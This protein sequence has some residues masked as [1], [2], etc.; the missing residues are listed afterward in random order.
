MQHLT[1]TGLQWGDEGKGKIVDVLADHYDVI[2]RFQGGHNAGHTLMIDGKTYKLSLL[3]SGIV[4]QDK[5]CVI[6]NGVVLD[7]AAL[8]QEI[9]TIRTAGIKVTQNRLKIADNTSLILP[10]HS[11]IEKERGQQDKIG[12]TARG[13]GPAYEDK[14]ARRGLRVCD[15]YDA[16]TL[17]NKVKQLVEFHNFWLQGAGKKL[18]NA[19]ENYAYLLQYRALLLEFSVNLFL[20]LDR[21]FQVGKRFMFEGAQGMMLDI[22]HGTYPYV[23]SSNTVATA[24]F[25]GGGM[26]VDSYRLGVTKAYCTRVGNGIFPSEDF[27]EDGEILADI[28]KELGTVTGRKRRCGWMD[29][30]LL[31]QAIKVSGIH[32][33]AL[34]KIDVLDHFAEI[35]ICT[36]YLC[37]EKRFDYLPYDQAEAKKLTPVYQTLPGW[38]QKLNLYQAFVDFPQEAKDFII[39]IEKLT[40]TKIVMVSTG[41]ERRD[42][43]WREVPDFMENFTRGDS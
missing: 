42:I 18:I 40:D 9:T 37:G 4:W 5:I 30:P 17:E 3:P 11:Y 19:D 13:I 23:T 26:A 6:G 16:T 20:F 21:Q 43:F 15:L 31:R 39:F 29:I 33:L 12:T 34:T 25:I 38:Q 28:G 27:G 7:A 35:K 36:H 14:I 10:L 32:A 41:P 22:D 2:I 8:A 24:A 1:V